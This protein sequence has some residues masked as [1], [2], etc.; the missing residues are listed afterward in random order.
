M[1]GV[2]K[3]GR[4]QTAGRVVMKERTGS[5]RRSVSP[6]VVERM[7]EKDKRTIRKELEVRNDQAVRKEEEARRRW[8]ANRPPLGVKTSGRLD[9]SLPQAVEPSDRKITDV[10][11]PQVC[12]FFRSPA[13]CS[14][15][16]CR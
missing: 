2:T 7:K 16:D 13:G 5:R 14:F 4:S 6:T 8:K 9:V 15:P 3:V 10:D 1:W 12:T 11:L